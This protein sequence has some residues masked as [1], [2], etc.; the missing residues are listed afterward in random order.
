MTQV[1]VMQTSQPENPGRMTVERSEAGAARHGVRG[2]RP[3]WRLKP[4]ETILPRSVG[5]PLKRV[6]RPC[7]W[8]WISNGPVRAGRERGDSRC[9]IPLVLVLCSAL[10]HLQP[11][12]LETTVDHSHYFGFLHTGSGC[13]IGAWLGA[14]GILCTVWTKEKKK[15]NSDGR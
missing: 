4:G 13:K 11:R 9:S 10:P 7:P 14:P 15:Q 5:A 3:E 2:D 8:S 12:L 1:S 6:S